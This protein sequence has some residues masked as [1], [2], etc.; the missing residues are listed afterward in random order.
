[1]SESQPTFGLSPEARYYIE[2]AA[3]AAASRAVEKMTAGDC[4]F[5]CDDITGVKATLYGANGKSGLTCDVAHLEEQVSGLVW[6]NRATIVAALSAVA[7]VIA[8]LLSAT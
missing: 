8:S 5:H 1:M 4:P 2:Q 7:A 3:E 6:W